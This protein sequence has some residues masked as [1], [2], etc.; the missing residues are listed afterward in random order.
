LQLTWFFLRGG[1]ES[2]GRQVVLNLAKAAVR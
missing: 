2:A 1:V